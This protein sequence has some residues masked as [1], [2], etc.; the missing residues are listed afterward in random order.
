MLLLT[1]IDEALA[2]LAA[3]D[4]RAAELVKQILAYSRRQTL[5]PAIVKL[6]DV[7]EEF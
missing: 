4:P 6:T 2:G 7:I 1:E 3:V 5:R